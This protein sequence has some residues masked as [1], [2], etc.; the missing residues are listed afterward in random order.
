MR[1]IIGG[2]GVVAATL[3]SGCSDK[4]EWMA[5]YDQCKE[6]VETQ[7]DEIKKSVAGAE[8]EQSR[9]MAKSM[10]ETALNMARAAC[11]MIRT[12]CEQDEDGAACR[13]YIEQARKRP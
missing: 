1:M 13:A 10:G 5:V 6:T 12:N 4:P 9:A 2:L 11:E 8:D 7:S 3:V